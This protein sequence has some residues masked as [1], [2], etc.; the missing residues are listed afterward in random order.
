MSLVYLS[1]ARAGFRGFY[2]EY[3]VKG[4]SLIL[5]TES[6][7]MVWSLREDTILMIWQRECVNYQLSWLRTNISMLQFSLYW[8]PQ[9]NL[10]HFS[11]A[12][13]TVNYQLSSL[14]PIILIFSL[15]VAEY[16][17][18]RMTDQSK[19]CLFSSGLVS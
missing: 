3:N 15:T 16:S 5:Y 12:V 10:L 8:P 7:I 1:I 19:V 11:A 6:N 4:S 2:S 9:T 17:S 14:T 18:Q 13:S